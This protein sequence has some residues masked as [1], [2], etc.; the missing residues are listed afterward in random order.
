V[1]H[2]PPQPHDDTETHPEQGPPDPEASGAVALPAWFGGVVV[3]QRHHEPVGE[4]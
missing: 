3:E 2:L 4:Q 1:A